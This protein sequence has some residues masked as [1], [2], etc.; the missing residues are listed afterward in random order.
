MVDIFLV[1][2]KKLSNITTS[3]TI[4]FADKIQYISNTHS[5]YGQGVEE[6]EKRCPRSWVRGNRQ[7]N[8]DSCYK[9]VRSP[10]KRWSDARLQCQAYR[11]QDKDNSDLASVN[12]LEEHE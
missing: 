4:H 6:D 5:E 10:D 11:H 8:R 3:I 2:K 1:S 12:S 9:F 7:S